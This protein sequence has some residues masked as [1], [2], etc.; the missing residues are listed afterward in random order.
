MR[1]MTWV[2]ALMAFSVILPHKMVGGIALGAD[3]LLAAAALL[4]LP[5]RLPAIVSARWTP[6]ILTVGLLWATI[7]V[8]G[9]V[10]GLAASLDI[11]GRLEMPTEMWQYVKRMAFFYVG[12]S[13]AYRRHDA[14]K[15]LALLVSSAVLIAG[16][17]GLA[18]ISDGA[19]S[20]A[21]ASIYAR[22]DFQLAKLVD[23]SIAARRVYGVAGHPVAWGGFCMLMACLA[24]PWLTEGTRTR[25]R[26]DN[27]WRLAAALLL[28]VALVNLLFSASRAAMAAF[29]TVLL[30]SGFIEIVNRRAGFFG[31][32][33]WAALVTGLGGGALLF[34]LDRLEFLVF[35]FIVL[36]ETSGGGRVDQVLSGWA[37]LDS[38]AA[39][40]SG[41]GNAVQRLR[42]VSFGV[43]VE[44]AYLLVNYGV[45]GAAAR[46]AL[47]VIIFYMGWRLAKSRS[48]WAANLGMTTVL[49]VP[50]YTVLSLGYFFF[51]ELY[52]GVTPWLL[53]GA[54][55]GAYQRV[56]SERTIVD[57]V[58]RQPTTQP[59]S[60]PASR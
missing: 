4:L 16:L 57:K 20:Q 6:L 33:R 39:W 50:G 8:H 27:W 47:L 36:G 43:E 59:S 37:L 58:S 29:G 25:L 28:A 15:V 7:I 13:I 32:A 10:L 30:F 2:F 18:Q 9:V 3:D 54:T 48:S 40:L 53:F 23:K 1:W 44:P 26:Q 35:R 42:G 17:I 5:L 12:F 52:V 19:L 41:V 46:Y 38:N 45:T 21:L 24:L 14:P 34:A 22:T 60:A 51:Q 56:I 55:A 49:L 11:L 31:I